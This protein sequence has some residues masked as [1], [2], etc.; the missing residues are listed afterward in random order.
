MINLT[1]KRQYNSLETY[2]I[3]ATAVSGKIHLPDNLPDFMVKPVT[4]AIQSEIDPRSRGAA[5]MFR[6]NA[7][8]KDDKVVSLEIKEG[9]I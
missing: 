7:K 1:K 9:M 4:A 8:V 6:L 5:T 2:L 3:E